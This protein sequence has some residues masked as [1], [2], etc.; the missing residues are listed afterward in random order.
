MLPFDKTHF[1][2]IEWVALVGFYENRLLSFKC[3]TGFGTKQ[4][5]PS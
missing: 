1:L 3:N 5:D 2:C 4:L